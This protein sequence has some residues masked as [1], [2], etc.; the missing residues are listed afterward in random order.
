MILRTLGLN[1]IQ[2]ISPYPLLSLKV[3]QTRGDNVESD[4]RK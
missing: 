3:G 4:K 1:T 2:F